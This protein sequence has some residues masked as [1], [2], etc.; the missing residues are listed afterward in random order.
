MA[1]ALKLEVITPERRVIEVTTPWVTLPGMAG[2]L[3]ILPQHVPLVT[4]IDSGVLRW[5]DAGREQRAAVHHGYAQVSNDRVTVLTELAE[6]S[7][8]ID[9]DRAA[10]AERRARTELRKLIDDAEESERRID[11]YEAKLRRAVTRQ[12]IVR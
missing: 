8:D 2:E 1:E 12:I 3:G 11:K 5:S 6:S 9:P 4:T 7:E 10:E